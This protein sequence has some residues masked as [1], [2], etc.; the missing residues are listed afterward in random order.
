LR[1]GVAGTLMSN[2]GLE[3]A[4]AGR[5]IPFARAAVGDRHVLGLLT[6]Q[7]WELGGETSGHI[8]CLDKSSTGDGIIAALQALAALKESGKTLGQLKAGM[9]ICPQRLINVHMKRRFD[10]KASAQVAGAVAEAERELGSQGRVVLRASG[11]EPVVRVMVEGRD[12]GQVERLAQSLAH[13]VQRAAEEA[14]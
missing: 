1:G 14:A 5:G 3:L 10:V 6:E 12:A 11:T 13:S 8:L 9:T 2:L 4:L 7:G